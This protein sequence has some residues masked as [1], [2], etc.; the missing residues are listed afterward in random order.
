[1]A[2]EAECVVTISSMDPFSGSTAKPLLQEKIQELISQFEK[3]ELPAFTNGPKILYD[4]QVTDGK[5][6][7]KLKV[8]YPKSYRNQEY[9]KFTA[10]VNRIEEIKFIMRK[11]EKAP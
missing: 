10:L 6:E 4:L 2:C 1:M 11:S 3:G 7:F 5:K 9:T 8:G